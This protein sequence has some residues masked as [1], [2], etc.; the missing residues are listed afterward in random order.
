MLVLPLLLVIFEDLAGFAFHSLV[1]L[2]ADPNQ[3]QEGGDQ[4][5]DDACADVDILLVRVLLLDGLEGDRL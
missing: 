3:E 5:D 2:E 4:D 1:L